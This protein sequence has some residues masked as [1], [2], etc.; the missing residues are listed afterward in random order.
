MFVLAFVVE[1]VVEYNSIMYKTQ[2][3]K[4]IIIFLAF[5]MIH[6]QNSTTTSKIITH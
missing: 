2:L 5:L 1:I 6:T 4:L 3:Q